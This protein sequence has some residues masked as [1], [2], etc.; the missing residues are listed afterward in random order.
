[1]STHDDTGR[2][3]LIADDNPDIHRDYRKIL[4]P[5]GSADG[6]Q[7]LEAEIFGRA[8]TE[9]PEPEHYE[10]DSAYQGAEALEMV[11]AALR[12]G[13]PYALA[14][15]DMRMPPGWDGLET[16]ERLWEVDH[17]IQVVI[18]TAYSDHSREDIVARTGRAHRLVILKKPFDTAEVAQ[19]AYAMTAKWRATRQAALKMSE[20]E[21]LVEQRTD[22]IA[23][24]NRELERRYAEL[25]RTKSALEQSE[26]RYALAAAGA[27]DGLW[28]WDLTTDLV[29]Y[30]PRWNA[31]I[32][33]P[34]EA[35][36]AAPE[37]WLSRVH[38]NEVTEVRRLID[39]HLAGRTPYLES[40]HRLRM[41]EGGYLWVLSRGIAIRDVAGRA[42]RMAG[43]MS[44]ISQRK[45]TEQEL[46]RGAYFDRL[47]GLPNRALFREC[48][49]EAIADRRDEASFAVL[50]LDFDNF[51]VVNDSLGHLAGDEL[52]VTAG[53][54]ISRCLKSAC[55]DAPTPTL[56]RL[57]GDEFVILLRGGLDPIAAAASIQAAFA[58]PI[59]VQGTEI[60]TSASI[61]I[62]VDDGAYATPDDV[63]RDADTAM[64][65]AKASGAGRCATF[66]AEMRDG[67]VARLS[68]ENE[69]RWAIQRGE[70][71]VAY[72]P[73]VDLETGITTG[74]EALARWT[75]PQQGPVSPDRFIPIA[76]ETGLIVPLGEHVLRR[77]CEDIK[78]LR[79]LNSGTRNLRVN[80]NLSSRQFSQPSLVACVM[81]M[82]RE[83]DLPPGALCL[84]VT[85]S[86][87]MDDVDAASATIRRLRDI[88]IEVYMDD[89]GT[90]YSS[91]SCLKLL[92]LTGLKLDRSFIAHLEDGSVVNPAIIHAVVTLAG[93]LHLNVVA[94]GVETPDQLAG[95]LALECGCAQGYHFGRPAGIETVLEL[96]SSDGEERRA[97]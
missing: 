91:L 16:I 11:T 35:T 92:P 68:L 86:V 18:C 23:E 8:G 7:C 45:E 22:E 70:I 90:G 39:A 56:A 48:L 54:R 13:R 57:G 63:L 10:V 58:E 1:M 81:D 73:I 69:L 61:G 17:E 15:V 97:A 96:L 62:T 29:H 43:S 33:L 36:D 88:G 28:D 40:E 72:Q 14:F 37:A 5:E 78:R 82:L 76:E 94:E 85:E 9:D 87:V 24:A 41:A 3:I 42:V 34:E 19:L 80:V 32:G 55:R 50:F 75:H 93:H 49:E 47:T 53:S 38:P 66:D 67:A 79:S 12:E 59:T 2:R 44:D 84:E 51:K 27:N 6:L 83:H 31:I 77:A 4:M 25:E 20:L 71:D 74:V 52:L 26:Q 95:V 21:L 64:Y 60:H 89:F 30:S 46:R 65:N